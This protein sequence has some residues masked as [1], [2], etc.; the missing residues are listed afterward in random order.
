MRP[1]P[2]QSQGGSMNLILYFMASGSSGFSL[3]VPSAS[4]KGE[5]YEYRTSL[6]KNS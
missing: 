6:A 1:N 4:I 3:L 2:R 5:D